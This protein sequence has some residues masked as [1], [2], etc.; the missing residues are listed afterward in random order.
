MREYAI[1]QNR[2]LVQQVRDMELPE[3]DWQTYN[4]TFLYRFHS[5]TD[6]LYVGVTVNPSGRWSAHRIYAV[7]WPLVNRVSV[8]MYPYTNAAL[9]AE[10]NAIRTEYPLFNTRSAARKNE[11]PFTEHSLNDHCSKH[12]PFIAG[13]EWN[14]KGMEWRSTYGEVSSYTYGLYCARSDGVT[15][16]IGGQ[17]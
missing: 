10:L 8:E 12:T 16:Q 13:M 14:G 5:T 9:D 2:S 1:D 11:G 3:R 7:W 6:L 17:P 4:R 15:A